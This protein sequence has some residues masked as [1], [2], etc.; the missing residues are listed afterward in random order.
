M[1][2]IVFALVQE[3]WL[4]ILLEVGASFV[5]ALV[6]GISFHMYEFEIVPRPANEAT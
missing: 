6:Q 5:P 3:S 2:S 4:G 1:E